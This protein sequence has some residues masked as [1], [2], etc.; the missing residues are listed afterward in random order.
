MSGR[1]LEKKAYQK[2]VSS[3]YQKRRYHLLIILRTL[4]F[5][6]DKQKATERLEQKQN[7]TWFT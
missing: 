3:A 1:Q 7:M 2:K 6:V 4:T 5:N